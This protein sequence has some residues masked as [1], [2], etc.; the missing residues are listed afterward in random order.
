[1]GK[2]LTKG[3]YCIKNRTPIAAEA[4]TNGCIIEVAEESVILRKLTFR[5][6]S[7]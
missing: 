2:E 3:E 5:K 1:M 7:F 6:K 4:K